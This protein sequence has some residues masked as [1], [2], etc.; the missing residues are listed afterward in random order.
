MR[1]WGVVFAF[2]SAAFAGCGGG[3]I[4]TYAVNGHVKFANG[5]PLHGGIIEFQ[6]VGEQKGKISARGQIQPDGSFQM[7]TFELHDGVI[8]G[9]HRVL[10]IPPMPPGKI[11]PTRLP[12]PVIHKRYERYET[13]GLEFTVTPDGTNTFEITVD[14]P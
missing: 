3:G 9:D 2:Y 12:K 14:P 10:I 11:D 1:R 13:S 7:S 5:K 8:A 4:D 6:P